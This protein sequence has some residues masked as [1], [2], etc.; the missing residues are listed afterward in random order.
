MIRTLSLYKRWCAR[1]PTSKLNSWLQ[2]W[3]IRWPPPWKHGAKC[4]VKY[5][6]QVNARPPTFV[7]WT[8]TAWDG[9]PRNYLRQLQN[10]MRDEFRISGVPMKFIMRSTLM[11]KP[12][13]VFKKSDILKWKRMGPKQAEAVT[14]LTAKKMLR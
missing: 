11:P 6:T 1:L 8:N 4:Q 10:T 9:I 3:M 12:H 7:V 2:A 13:K 5:M 14:N